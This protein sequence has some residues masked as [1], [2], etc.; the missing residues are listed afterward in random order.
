MG[1]EVTRATPQDAAELAAIHCEALPPG[2]SS[3]EIAAAC[4]APERSVLKAISGGKLSG[5]VILQI[6]AGEAEILTIAVT[7]K[8]RRQGGASLLMAA[9]IEACHQRLVSF[10]FLETAQNNI[11]ARAL[12]EKFGFSVVGQ[13]KNYYQTGRSAPETA[14]IMKLDIAGRRS[15]G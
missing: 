12:Y 10:V 1:F 4:N 7:T 5:F 11:S 6:A 13:R 9:A 8:K 15:L 2:W 14:L 3:T